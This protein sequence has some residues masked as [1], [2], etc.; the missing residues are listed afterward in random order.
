MPGVVAVVRDGSFLGVVAEREEQAIKAVEALSAAAKWKAGPA[1]ARSGTAL[2]AAEDDADAGHR[3]QQQGGAA[4]GVRRQGG[5]GDLSPAVPGACRAGAVLRG[6]AVPGRQVDRLDAQPGRLS[7][8]RNDRP[9]ARHEPPS[10]RCI[11]MEGAGCYGHNGADDVAFDAA[12]LARATNGRPVRVQWMRAEEFMWEPYGPAMAMKAKGAVAD[13]RIVDWHYDVWSQ[14][15]NM[16]PAIRTA[17]T[18][19]RAGISPIRSRRGRRG[20][21]I[22]RTSPATAMRSRPTTCR[23]RRSRTI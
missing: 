11:H 13:G 6:R 14:S 3:H 12:L 19:C 4:A 5:R 2:R 20:R 15:H 9:G 17:S 21:P 22:R 23:G 10:I 16:R 18:C 8:A 1:T 7:A